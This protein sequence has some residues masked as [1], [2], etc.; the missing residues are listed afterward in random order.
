MCLFADWFCS[1]SSQAAGNE[2]AAPL[3]AT[4]SEELS[5]AGTNADNNHY[6]SLVHPSDT[7]GPES[8]SSPTT[9]AN[10]AGP[11]LYNT[12]VHSTGT[13][14]YESCDPPTNAQQPGSNADPAQ[15]D[16]LM[17]SPVTS[18]FESCDGLTGGQQPGNNAGHPLY[19]TLVHSTDTSGYE[20]CDPPTNAQQ[21]GSNADPAQYDALMRSPVTSVYE[22]CDG[23]T[24]VQQPGNNAGYE[25]DKL[26]RLPPGPKPD[27]PDTIRDPP[28]PPRQPANRPYEICDSGNNEHLPDNAT[29]VPAATE[30]RQYANVNEPRAS[31]QPLGNNSGYEEYDRLASPPRSSGYEISSPGSAPDEQG[32]IRDPPHLANHPA[33]LSHEPIT[34]PRAARDSVEYNTP[35][36]PPYDND[37]L[38]KYGRDMPALPPYE[39]VAQV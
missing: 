20:S 16:A 8:G 23:P 33:N 15:Y 22:S 18:V 28:Y 24:D 3:P 32:T 34:D 1:C 12:L 9:P 25:Y 29:A 13:S 14:G 2:Y 5:Q 31:A 4:I 19:N 7:S 11:P 26:S 17:R 35:A 39:N 37:R 36:S 21:P 6:N 10:N 27:P 30:N 38:K